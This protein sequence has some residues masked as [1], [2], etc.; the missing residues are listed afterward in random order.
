M[1]Q[2]VLG[3]GTESAGAVAEKRREKEE[4]REARRQKNREK[5]SA[6]PEPEKILG[7]AHRIIISA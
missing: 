6:V 4:G 7:T 2:N 5:I 1:E 3:I